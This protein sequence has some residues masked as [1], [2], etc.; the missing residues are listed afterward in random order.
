MRLWLIKGWKETP[1]PKQS[2]NNY[3]TQTKIKTKQKRDYVMDNK[4]RPYDY[5]SYI[6]TYT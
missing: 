1:K 3:K 6:H 5:A 2:K 4:K